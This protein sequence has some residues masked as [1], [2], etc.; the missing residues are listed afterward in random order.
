MRTAYIGIRLTQQEKRALIAMSK[1]EGLC[2]S[3]YARRIL[4]AQLIAQ[5]AIKI[6]NP[7]PQGNQITQG[8]N[9]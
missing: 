2:E 1:V 5:G 3:S 4:R 8:A 9:S 7:A 6:T